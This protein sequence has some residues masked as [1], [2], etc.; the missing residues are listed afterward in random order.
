MLL[1][2]LIFIALFAVFTLVLLGFL[3]LGS[4]SVLLT[5][6][7]VAMPVFGFIHYLAFGYL[8]VHIRSYFNTENSISNAMMEYVNKINNKRKEESND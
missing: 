1:A 8:L 4:I 2:I 3:V 5:A 7:G 6:F